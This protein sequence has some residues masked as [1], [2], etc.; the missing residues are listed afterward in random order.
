M[1]LVC[2][3]KDVMK[4][5]MKQKPLI[6]SS[7]DNSVMHKVYFLQNTSCWQKITVKRCVK[8][9]CITK[10]FMFQMESTFKRM[11]KILFKTKMQL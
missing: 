4:K 10:Q 3:D 7:V 9:C 6:T 2:K 1:Y 8:R 11:G 5:Y